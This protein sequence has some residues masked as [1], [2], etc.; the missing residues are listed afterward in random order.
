MIDKSNLNQL[1]VVHY[2]VEK[3]KRINAKPRGVISIVNDDDS[4]DLLER[5]RDGDE[6]AAGILFD[7]YVN[8]LVGLAR[9]R[10]SNQMKRRVEPEDVVHSAYRSFFRKAGDQRYQL[11]KSGDLWRLLAAITISKLRGQVEFHTAQKRAV[12][13]EESME[14]DRSTFRVRPEAIMREPSPS[15]AALIVEELDR[16]MRELE[17]IQR[18]IM[19]LALQNNSVEEISASV[20][21]SGRTVRRTI[22]TIRECLERRLL[23]NNE[24]AT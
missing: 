18:E 9:N 24:Q 23:E 11:E 21:R 8:Q 2:P 6:Q 10:L 1:E 3:Y 14:S 13:S 5:W 20:K 15:D 16:I 12:Y 19:E 22:Q 17:P 7:R 4:V